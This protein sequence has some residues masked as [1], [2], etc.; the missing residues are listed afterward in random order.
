MMWPAFGITT[1]CEEEFSMNRPIKCER[2]V[3]TTGAGYE[4]PVPFSGEYKMVRNEFLKILLQMVGRDDS[5]GELSAATRACEELLPQEI[6]LFFHAMDWTPA[7]QDLMTL[8]TVFYCNQDR[9]PSWGEFRASLRDHVTEY[10]SIMS[11]EQR[12]AFEQL[13]SCDFQ[14]LAQALLAASVLKKG[15][16]VAEYKEVKPRDSTKPANPETAKRVQQISQP[17]PKPVQQRKPRPKVVQPID[18]ELPDSFK[19]IKPEILAS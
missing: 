7:E 3:A 11:P 2:T 19:L 5:Q 13:L 15:A 14:Q 1:E 6:D 16:K 12:T 9:A 18:P 4:L 17:T 10:G 8:L